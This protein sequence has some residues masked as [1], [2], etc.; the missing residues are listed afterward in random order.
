M[1]GK[2]RYEE[3]RE[4]ARSPERLQREAA[5]ALIASTAVSPR[6]AEARR[7]PPKGL[8]RCDSQSP[9]PEA[10]RGREHFGARG[11]AHA[12]CAIAQQG[13]GRGPRAPGRAAG[14]LGW[15]GQG[16]AALAS[17]SRASREGCAGCGAQ[18]RGGQAATRAAA[19]R[20]DSPGRLNAPIGPRRANWRPRLFCKGGVA[21]TPRAAAETLGPR[22]A[23][24]TKRAGGRSAARL[25]PRAPPRVHTPRVL[26]PF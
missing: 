10:P 13:C 5:V 17:G 11:S 4:G 23:A 9:L 25:W 24:S 3:E 8:F 26:K 15:A 18:R 21:S 20:A 22:L 7:E 16:K 1:G 6:D 19:A 12:P 14:G 2:E